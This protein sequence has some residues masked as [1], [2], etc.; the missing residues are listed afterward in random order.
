ME[1]IESFPVIAVIL[2]AL[3]LPTEARINAEIGRAH[4]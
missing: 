3:S 2:G 4:V 1:S